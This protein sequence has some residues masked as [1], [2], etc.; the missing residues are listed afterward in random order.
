M[1]LIFLYYLIYKK[2]TINFNPFQKKLFAVK[3]SFQSQQ[4][5]N[6]NR[7]QERQLISRQLK[8]FN[9]HCK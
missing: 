4:I 7:S 9:Y 5:N 2:I 6:K 1:V 8:V 3:E